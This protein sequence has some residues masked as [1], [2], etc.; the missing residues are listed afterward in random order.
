MSD[1]YTPDGAYSVVAVVLFFA[2]I[3]VV[4]SA[5]VVMWVLHMGGVV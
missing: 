4:C 2:T 1:D 5:L 3:I